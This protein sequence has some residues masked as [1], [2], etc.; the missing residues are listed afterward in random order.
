MKLEIEPTDEI[1]EVEGAPCR[2]WTGT[3]EHGTP[4]HVM[5][6]ALSPQSH[7]P[8]VEARYRK[9]L[10]ELD[11]PEERVNVRDLRIVS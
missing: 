3:D 5:V 11:F 7:D 8:V 4:V 10:H 1:F 2:L 9:H 6:R